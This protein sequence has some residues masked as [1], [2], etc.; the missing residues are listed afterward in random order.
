MCGITGVV[1]P[2]QS[3]AKDYLGLSERV[4]IH[5]G[6]DFQSSEIVAAE[7]GASVWAINAS[8]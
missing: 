5:R 4:Q 2:S 3:L 7:I 8:L 6:T 1:C